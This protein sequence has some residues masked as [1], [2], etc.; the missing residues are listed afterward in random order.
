V[1]RVIAEAML[2]GL[3]WVPGAL[4]LPVG[5][6]YSAEDGGWLV[7]D[8]GGVLPGAV[9]VTLVVG[10]GGLEVCDGVG[11]VTPPVVTLTS[12]KLAVE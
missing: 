7:D 10:V 5:E 3:D 2:V 1:T 4:A 12:S 9:G 11:F 8:E 6:T